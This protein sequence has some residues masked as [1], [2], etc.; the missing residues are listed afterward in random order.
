MTDEQPIWRYVE[1]DGELYEFCTPR[2]CPLLS[3][4]L[5]GKC[6]KCRHKKSPSH[7]HCIIIMGYEGFACPAS[8]IPN[9]GVCPK[10]NGDGKNMNLKLRCVEC[11]HCNGTGKVP[12]VAKC[13]FCVGTGQLTS[14]ENGTMYQCPR[15]KG[16]GVL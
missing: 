8:V 2:E 12:L 5:G 15:C 4:D 6:Y 10:C 7:G 3:Y 16:K 1:I 13:P 11:L 9:V 14:F